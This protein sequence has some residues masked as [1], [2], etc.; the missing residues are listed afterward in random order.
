LLLLFRQIININR[1]WS[2]GGI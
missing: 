2:R 1:V